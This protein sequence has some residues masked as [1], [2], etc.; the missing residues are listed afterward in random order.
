MDKKQGVSGGLHEGAWECIYLGNMTHFDLDPKSTNPTTC[1]LCSKRLYSTNAWERSKPP[2]P[3]H[4]NPRKLSVGTKK[5]QGVLKGP[6]DFV[7]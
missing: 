3:R 4:E 7:I 5:R 6:N 1:L 2:T